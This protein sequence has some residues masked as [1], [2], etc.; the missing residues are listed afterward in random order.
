MFQ[1]AVLSLNILTLSRS[2]AIPCKFNFFIY[3]LTKLDDDAKEKHMENYM[4]VLLFK[5]LLV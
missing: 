4:N 2:V 5:I 3:K 1:S